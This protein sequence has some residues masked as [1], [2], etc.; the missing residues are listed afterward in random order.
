MAK[1]PRIS[2]MGDPKW[3]EEQPHTPQEWDPKLG[4]KQLCSQKDPPKRVLG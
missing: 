4:E 1:Q 2:Q 3:V